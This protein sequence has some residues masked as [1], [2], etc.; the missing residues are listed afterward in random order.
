MYL[1]RFLINYFISYFNQL[2]IQFS[3]KY[4]VY[5]DILINIKENISF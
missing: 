1:K 2:C 4:K 5:D 3:R